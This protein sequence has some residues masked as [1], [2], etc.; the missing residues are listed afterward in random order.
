MVSSSSFRKTS[1]QVL[2]RHQKIWTEFKHLLEI[3]KTHAQITVKSAE[4]ATF[5]VKIRL[6]EI[7]K[8]TTTVSEPYIQNKLKYLTYYE[9]HLSKQ[10]LQII[11]GYHPYQ[12]F[13]ATIVSNY[14]FLLQMVMQRCYCMS[15]TKNNPLV[16]LF[17]EVILRLQN[18][19]H[20]LFCDCSPFS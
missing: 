2:I 3:Q 1:Q 10:F 19:V 16:H 8:F 11:S 17:F 6:S 18:N 12:D 9:E 4:F 7:L 14:Y 20:Q 15:T 5:Q 13:E